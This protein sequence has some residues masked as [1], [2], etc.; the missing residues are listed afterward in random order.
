M[1]GGGEEVASII[2]VLLNK[3]CTGDSGVIVIRART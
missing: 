1:R 3:D 2:G